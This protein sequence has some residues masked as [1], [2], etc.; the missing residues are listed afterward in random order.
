MTFLEVFLA[1]CVWSL[2]RTLLPGRMDVVRSL[3]HLAH[4][5][6]KMYKPVS[7]LRVG[8]RLATTDKWVAGTPTWQAHGPCDVGEWTIPVQYVDGTV[9]EYKWRFQNITVYR[10]DEQWYAKPARRAANTILRWGKK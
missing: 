4:I 9:G 1:L 2:L 10:R 7:E 6:S 3:N 8:E 5:G